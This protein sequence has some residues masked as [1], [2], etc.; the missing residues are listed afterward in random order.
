MALPQRKQLEIDLPSVSK[1][2]IAIIDPTTGAKHDGVRLHYHFVS[3]A[4]VPRAMA[5][6]GTVNTGLLLTADDARADAVRAAC[7]SD[8]VNQRLRNIDVGSVFDPSLPTCRAAI[9]AEAT[10]IAA[11][12]AHLAHPDHEVIPAELTRTYAPISLHLRPLVV[13]RDAGAP[14]PLANAAG[15]ATAP[16]R[17]ATAGPPVLAQDALPVAAARHV[18]LIADEAKKLTEPGPPAQVDVEAPPPNT[19]VADPIRYAPNP[20]DSLASALLVERDLDRDSAAE[21]SELFQKDRLAAIAAGFVTP[22]AGG[23]ASPGPAPGGGAY[24][25]PNFITLYWALGMMAL[26]LVGNRARKR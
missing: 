5:E 23:E 24:T 1:E 18:D 20:V 25:A 7:T 11:S 8:A 17:P 4:L 19:L 3:S 14:P 2:P 10:V 26:L 6:Q 22:A 16:S 9:A 13:S 15:A 12:R 21:E